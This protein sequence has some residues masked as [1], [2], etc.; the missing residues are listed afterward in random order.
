ME[1]VSDGP[2]TDGPVSDPPEGEAAQGDGVV[3]AVK[4]E[5][6]GRTRNG[7]TPLPFSCLLSPSTS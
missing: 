2:A 4:A 5:G 1:P 3:S 7:E 6:L